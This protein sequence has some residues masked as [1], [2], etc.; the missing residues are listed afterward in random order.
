MPNPVPCS[1]LANNSFQNGKKVIALSTYSLLEITLL[2]NRKRWRE[3][4]ITSIVVNCGGGEENADKSL[5]LWEKKRKERRVVAWD[6][7]P[8]E[9]PGD[10]GN[11]LWNKILNIL[12]VNSYW[13]K[14]TNLNKYNSH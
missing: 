12:P 11:F 8:A 4:E 14:I 5:W 7:N 2:K 13:L 1:N 6:T 10:L 3:T 9:C